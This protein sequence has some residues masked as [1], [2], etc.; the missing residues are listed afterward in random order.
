M[1]ERSYTARGSTNWD[2]FYKGSF[3]NIYQI[4]KARTLSSSSSISR[5]SLYR[6][7]MARYTNLVAWTLK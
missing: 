7:A 6:Y 5:N 4:I 2:N 3:G 1:C